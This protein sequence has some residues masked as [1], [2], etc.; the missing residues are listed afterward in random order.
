[1]FR[2]QKYI[3][4]VCQIDVECVALFY[5]AGDELPKHAW[6]VSKM[7][8]LTAGVQYEP[9]GKHLKH[10]LSHTLCMVWIT[11]LM[12]SWKSDRILTGLV[13]DLHFSLL[14]NHLLM[15]I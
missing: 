12:F 9:Q 8:R 6:L 5:P 10:V 1:M 2:S 13:S 3:S 7:G 14:S 4:K 11:C 15:L